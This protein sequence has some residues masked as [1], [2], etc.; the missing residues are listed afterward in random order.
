MCTLPYMFRM[1]GQ[2]AR[3]AVLMSLALANK[4][5]IGHVIVHNYMT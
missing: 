4:A 2:R 3:R 5:D 1:P